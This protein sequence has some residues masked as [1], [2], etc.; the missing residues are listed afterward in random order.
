MF[1]FEV[2]PYQEA[3]AGGIGKAEQPLELVGKG[4]LALRHD[5]EDCTVL[6]FGKHEQVC[7]SG[8]QRYGG[9]GEIEAVF[10]A[11][12]VSLAGVVPG[13]RRIFDDRLLITSGEIDETRG[14]AVF[15]G[16]PAE[17]ADEFLVTVEFMLVAAGGIG[18]DSGQGFDGDAGEEFGEIARLHGVYPKRG[19]SKTP[20]SS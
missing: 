16:S 2:L 3:K 19:S 6:A 4:G 11:G 10:G 14:I 20:V 9:S 8:T 15:F 17:D 12:G 13:Y 1:G 5:D 7:F 18:L